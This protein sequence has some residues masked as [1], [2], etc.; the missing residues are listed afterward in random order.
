MS[1]N[2]K[3]SLVYL[4]SNLLFKVLWF[5]LYSRA[6]VSYCLSEAIKLSVV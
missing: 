1:A 5:C 3:D 2:T 6:L 4:K